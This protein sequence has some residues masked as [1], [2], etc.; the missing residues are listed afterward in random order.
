[1]GK[2]KPSKFLTSLVCKDDQVTL[3]CSKSYSRILILSSV[4][5]PAATAPIYCPL[6]H[7]EYQQDYPNKEY[8]QD[9]QDCTHT[10][11]TEYFIEL[12][13]GQKTCNI[14]ASP[15][16][17]GAPVCEDQFVYLKTVYACVDMR[18]IIEEYVDRKHEPSSKTLLIDTESTV[19]PIKLETG[20]SISETSDK[21]PLKS[22]NT[23]DSVMEEPNHNIKVDDHFNETSNKDITHN[24]ESDFIEVDNIP[25]DIIKQENNITI[26]PIK[27]EASR[28]IVVKK[29]ALK[30]SDI[31]D[32]IA[33][34]E[35]NILSEDI[36]LDILPLEQDPNTVSV[37]TTDTNENILEY[38]E[39]YR[40]VIGGIL[41]MVL[42]IILLSILCI[43]AIPL[44]HTCKQ[45]QR[46]K[47]EQQQ[48]QQQ[49]YST[50]QQSQLSFIV[51]LDN[52]GPPP[53]LLPVPELF[54]SEPCADQCPEVKQKCRTKKEV[55][56]NSSSCSFEKLINSRK[57]Q[58]V[59][60]KASATRTS[61]GFRD[62]K[63]WNF[64][65]RDSKFYDAFYH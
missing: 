48:Q 7:E 21:D 29:K 9:S 62:S 32:S 10:P 15:Q 35:Y 43:L 65:K 2:C 53:Y 30:T 12:C 64:G 47:Q 16:Q 24:L 45:Q 26:T 61:S 58:D 59:I 31:L 33:T 55:E 46:N 42:I 23:S 56:R 11:V 3:S 6:Y 34:R 57:T 63:N 51:E 52:Q 4:F 27:E 8:G 5:S 40:T 50:Q 44:I 39:E 60:K 28:E 18:T 37:V 25:T 14:T 54:T 41:V 36:N 38:F 17:L 49:Q 20:E 1:M 19:I 13:Q 22:I